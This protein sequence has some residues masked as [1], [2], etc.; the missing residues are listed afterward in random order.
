LTSVDNLRI[1]SVMKMHC[2]RQIK[3]LSKWPA[4]WEEKPWLVSP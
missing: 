3:Y 2:V 1:E 4:E